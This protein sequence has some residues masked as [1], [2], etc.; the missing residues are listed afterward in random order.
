MESRISV[1]T[2][3]ADDIIAMKNF[4]KQ[5]LG[6]YP[7]AE[8]NDIAFYKMNG[9]LLS[10]CD[11]KVLEDFTGLAAPAGSPSKMT[12]GYNVKTNEEVMEIYDRLKDK[13][14]IIKEPIEPP[15]GGLIFYFSDIEGNIFEVASNP[16]ITLDQDKNAVDHKTIGHI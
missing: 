4:Y 10:I 11:R 16:Y 12:L 3:P 1:L 15:F 13:V 2:I 9:F 8:N 5:T 7:L 14:R 6:W